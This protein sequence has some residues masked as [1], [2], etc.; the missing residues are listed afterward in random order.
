M[1]LQRNFYRFCTAVQIF[2]ILLLSFGFLF[3]SIQLVSAQSAQRKPALIRDT[4]TAEGKETADTSAAKEPNPMLSEHNLN[5]GNFYFKKR[6]YA[7]A[8][9]RYLEA[10]Q[11]QPDSVRA[12]EALARAYEKY[13]QPEKAIATYKQFI[14]KY[15]NA[16]KSGDF[17]ARLAKLEKNSG[18]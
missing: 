16:P 8:I 2:Q 6:N 4:D 10:I 1:D 13:E 5:I 17:R 9:A 12:C 3:F 18:K 7:A 14:E 15:P 11:Y